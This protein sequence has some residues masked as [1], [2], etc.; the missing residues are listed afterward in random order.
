MFWHDYSHFFCFSA[1]L[2]KKKKKLTCFNLK[3]F[4]CNDLPSGRPAHLSFIPSAIAVCFGEGT[5]ALGFCRG[6][7]EANSV[8]GLVKE[9]RE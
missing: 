4:R 6:L 1:A 2:R 5:E 7:S 3:L 9:E 8:G